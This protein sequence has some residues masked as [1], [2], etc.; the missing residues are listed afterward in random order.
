VPPEHV[1]VFDEAQRA[2]DRAQVA[3]KHFDL[4][5]HAKSE[6]ELFVEFAERIPE[7]CVVVGLIG[8]GQEIHK[9]E[10]GGLAQWRDAI[11]RSPR[12]HEWT[13][14]APRHVEPLL[15]LAERTVAVDERLNLTTE[16]RFHL[17]KDVHAFVADLLGGRPADDLQ[18][19]AAALEAAGYHLR[20]TRDL[21][22]AKH[23]LWE[24]YAS[25]PEKRFGLLASSRDKRLE[26]DFGVP[27][28]FQATKNVKV[29]PWYADPQE[30]AAGHS[31]RRLVACVTEF[32]AQGL[33]LDAA[34]VAWGS[35]FVRAA[36]ADGH[37][38]W[39][40]G[41]ARKY[42]KDAVPVRNPEQLRLNSY[43]VLLTRG[44]EA[45]VLFVPPRPHW[46]ATWDYLRAAGLR[47]LT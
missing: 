6:P 46:D 14:H 22:Q 13:V 8:G 16:L 21:E 23:Y 45:T 41:D 29:G 36:D 38:T 32:G 3:A 12:A 47:E 5:V 34:L 33:E 17:T 30:H 7:W 9:G 18:P 44:R 1:L 27:N 11:A 24:R 35:D 2:W 26:D 28:S 40:I 20:I 4:H 39:S 19:R 25:E 43:R 31:C 15:R 37:T 10:E 42:K